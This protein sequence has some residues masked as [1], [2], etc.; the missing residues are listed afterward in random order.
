MPND[1]SLR[2]LVR[3]AL[4]V[5]LCVAAV[6]TAR[7]A[8]SRVETY[9]DALTLTLSARERDT[10]EQIPELDRRLLA[11]RA[12]V[13]AGPNLNARWSWTRAEIERY[14][15]S[16]EYRRLLADLELVQQAFER[17]NPGYTLYANREVRSLD[18]QIERWN[19][20]RGVKKT[21]ANL[22]AFVAAKLPQLAERPDIEGL[23]AFR[24]LLSSWSPAPV[25]P[26]AAPGLSLHGRMRAI[27]FQIMRNGQI[28]AATEV[29]ASGRDWQATGW[30]GKLKQAVVTGGGR[31][32]GP[33][34][35]PNEP[36]HYEYKDT[37]GG[38]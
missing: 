3:H 38:G 17:A 11:I 6:D 22:Q 12:Y 25:A 15:T 1:A 7:A 33:L 10:L 29:G 32:A 30:S 19:S 36:W 37:S 24:G 13:R 18:T 9:V 4:C 2:N 16:D 8:A 34:I 31:F 14:M 21:A 27:D 28:V 23:K 26:L 20:N 5:L 35:S